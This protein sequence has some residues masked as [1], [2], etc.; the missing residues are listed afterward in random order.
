MATTRFT[1][2]LFFLLLILIGVSGCCDICSSCCKEPVDDPCVRPSTIAANQNICPSPKEISFSVR[3]FK[4]DPANSSERKISL[5]YVCN[6][7]IIDKSDKDLVYDS[8]LPVLKKHGYVKIK[9]CP[10][11]ENFELWE[12]SDISVDPIDVVPP[13]PVAGTGTVRSVG[14][15]N[16]YLN[17]DTIAISDLELPESLTG[18]MIECRGPDGVKIA[19][20]DSGVE[21]DPNQFLSY[22]RQ[23]PEGNWN[24]FNNGIPC[25]KSSTNQYGINMVL[26][27]SSFGSEPDDK[28]GHGTAVNAVL[29]GRSVPNFG[30]TIDMKINN[31]AIFGT[32]SGAGTLFDA[33]CGLQ[34][35]IDQQSQIINM[36]WGLSYGNTHSDSKVILIIDKLK[37][38]F[39][40]IFRS[41][42]DILFVAGAGNDSCVMG[43]YLFFPAC[44]ANSDSVNNLIS[45][46]A[47]NKK[48]DGLA[49]FSN[50]D[51]SGVGRMVDFYVTGERIIAPAIPENAD[52]ISGSTRTLKYMSGTS[53]AAPL[54]SRMA[55]IL[56]SQ[57]LSPA[58]VKQRLKSICGTNFYC[59]KIGGDLIKIDRSSLQKCLC[60]LR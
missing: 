51:T 34:Y 39:R 54:V 2:L 53:Y 33:L 60:D 18:K 26:S 10:C 16:F 9:T 46:G 55:S 29:A 44:L 3:N 23:R 41:N 13:P 32:A 24:Y 28:M 52:L 30:L 19:I 15:P 58:D 45:V 47:L 50:F 43:D 20:L 56:I 11:G 59:D 6:Q 25:C 22:L 40:G 21:L 57:G 49:E 12:S 27:S 1:N 36:S 5:K 7:L 37:E 35:A 48:E 4:L 17:E 38:Q 14:V 31:V 8:I 42:P